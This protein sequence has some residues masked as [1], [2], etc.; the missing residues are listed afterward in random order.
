VSDVDGVVQDSYPPRVLVTANVTPGSF[1]TIYRITN[2]TSQAIRGALD[3]FVSSAALVVVDAEI[4]FGTTFRYVL[5]ENGANVDTSPVFNVTLTGGMV[6]LSDA[7]TGLSAEVAVLAID[8]LDRDAQAAVYNVDGLNKVVSS[9]IGQ[10]QHTI[11]YFTETLTARDDLRILLEQC[12]QGIFLQRAPNPGYDA[13]YYLSVLRTRERRWSQDGSDPRRVTA[14]QVAQSGAWPLEL[15]ARGY[16]Y[17]DVADAYF[18]LDYD[19]L[20]ADFAT[21]LALAQGDFG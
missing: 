2:S 6:A 19:D 15:E 20:P 11:E 18:G 13:D 3:V 10:P 17:E 4:P 12:T 1:I 8:D 16:T 5:V 9:R 14:V 7:I 21:Y